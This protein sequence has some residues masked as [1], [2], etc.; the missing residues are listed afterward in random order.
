MALRGRP[1]GGGC[2]PPSGAL[3]KSQGIERDGK[4]RMIS[5]SGVIQEDERERTT[6]DV[7][8]VYG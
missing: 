4:R 5:P 2:K 1:A 7:S 3:V 6:D 8:K